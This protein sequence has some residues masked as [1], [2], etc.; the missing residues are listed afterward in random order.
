[1]ERHFEVIIIGGGIVGCSL[2]FTLSNFTNISSIALVEKNSRIGLGNSNQQNNSKTLHEGFAET[3]YSFEKMKKMKFA[4]SLIKKYLAK[5]IKYIPFFKENKKEIGFR[6]PF[7]VLATNE[8]EIKLLENKYTQIKKLFPEVELKEGEDIKKIEPVIVEGRK[9]KVLAIYKPDGFSINFGKLTEEFVKDSLNKNKNIQI[10]FNSEVKSIMEKIEKIE[11]ICNDRKLTCNYLIVAASGNSYYIAKKLGYLNEYALI[12]VRGNY[13]T[14]PLI[15]KSKIYRPQ[16]EKIPFVAPHADPNPFSEPEHME[17]GPTAEIT[18]TKEFKNRFD[19]KYLIDLFS[20]L[21]FFHSSL[22]I[23]KDIQIRKFLLKNFLYKLPYIGKDLFYEE[24]KKIIPKLNKD[25]LK[26]IK[27]GIRPQL[28]DL[29]RKELV[30]GERN[31]YFNK[32][33]F[34]ITPSPGASAS[35]LNAIEICNKI[36]NEMDYKF[37]IEEYLK[38]L[39]FSKDDEKTI[40]GIL[41]L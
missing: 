34:C 11:V 12:H 25:K 10:F 31:F 33:T 18:L 16:I 6:L 39:D 8:N 35:M 21:N 36:C 41:N 30:L 38:Y 28:V 4:S 19:P 24:A 37:Y 9:E 13:Y 20:N 3:N 29:K 40:Y 26:L 14:Y 15:I 2:L 27:G 1:V 7:F 32:I 5:K 22:N 17:I 23:I